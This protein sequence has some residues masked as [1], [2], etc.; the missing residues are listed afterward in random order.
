MDGITTAFTEGA[1]TI[2]TNLTNLVAGIVPVVL[3]ILGVVIAVGMG[4][5]IIKK[6]T[7]R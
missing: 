2:V 5:K 6:V 3:P 4:I 1:G 7:G